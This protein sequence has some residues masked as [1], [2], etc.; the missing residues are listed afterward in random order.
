MAPPSTCPAVIP[1]V[2]AHSHQQCRRPVPER[3]VRERARNRSPRDA[4]APAPSAPL[5]G[6]DNAA[7]Q[8]RPIRAEVLSDAPEDELVESAERG[9]AGRGEGSVEHVE[10]FRAV[11][12]GTSIEEDLDPYPAIAA[13]PA[14]HPQLRSVTKP[15]PLL[16]TIPYALMCAQTSSRLIP[17][18]RVAFHDT[19]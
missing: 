8:H 13:D 18:V 3:L 17:E 12:V 16:P 19:L 5:V 9:E 6:L 4:L 14:L 2:A 10:V 1:L 7:L 15:S 11:S